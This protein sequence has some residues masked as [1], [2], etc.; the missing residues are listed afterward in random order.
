[1]GFDI[2]VHDQSV[3]SVFVIFYMNYVYQNKHDFKIPQCC[4][5]FFS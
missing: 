2:V 1:M 3:Y 5:F 4:I